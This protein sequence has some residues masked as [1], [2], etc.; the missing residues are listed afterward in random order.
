MKHCSP[1]LTSCF[2]TTNAIFDNPTSITW[3][4]T[5][6]RQYFETFRSQS[7]GTRQHLWAWLFQGTHFRFLHVAI[8]ASISSPRSEVLGGSR[9]GSRRKDRYPVHR[10]LLYLHVQPTQT[11]HRWFWLSTILS[12]LEKWCMNKE[13]A[14]TQT[15]TACN[16]TCL[17][18]SLLRIPV[19]CFPSTSTLTLTD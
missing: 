2:S 1:C 19:C 6:R 4:H 18:A 7:L 14:R 16:R 15:P 11:Q 5:S 3:N 13:E 17:V 8:D 12:I 9:K 10:S